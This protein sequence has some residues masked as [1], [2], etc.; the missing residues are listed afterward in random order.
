MEEGAFKVVFVLAIIIGCIVIIGFFLL[1]M[2]I[3]LLF[4]PEINLMGLTIT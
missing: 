4:M 1:L 2:K 3:L